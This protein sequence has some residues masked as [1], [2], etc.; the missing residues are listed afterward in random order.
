MKE[1][2]L[3]FSPANRK[4]KA[5]ETLM[6]RKLVSFSTLSGH[7]CPGADKCQSFAI[8]TPDGLRIRDGKHNEFRCFSASQEVLYRNVYNSR[9]Q[10]EELLRVAAVN[11]SK[12]VDLIRDNFPAKATLCRL[13]VAGD[14]KTQNYFDAWLQF[15][16]ETPKVHFYAYTKSIPFWVKRLGNIPKNFVLTASIGGKYD[17]LA[18]GNNLRTATV[19]ETAADVPKGIPV[20]HNDK[21]AAMPRY[22]DKSFA[23]LLHGTQVGRKAQYGYGKMKVGE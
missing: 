17:A 15:A 10:N 4:L 19:Y 7:N 6:K 13:H 22:R 18:I 5:L 16:T 14:F 8:E 20:D 21:Y 1:V 23:L 11:I 2:M 9:K 3:K 12:A